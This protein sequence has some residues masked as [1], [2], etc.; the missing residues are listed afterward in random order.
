MD[1]L[2]RA[3][4]VRVRLARAVVA[5]V[6]LAGARQ[7]RHLL[8]DVRAGRGLRPRAAAGSVEGELRRAAER[9]AHQ[10]HGPEDVRP[11]HRRPRGDGRS[12][13]VA[14]HRVHRA[15]AERRD[16]RQRVAHRVQAAE[17]TE[18]AVVVR[19]PAGGAAVAALV[20]GDDVVARVGQRRQDVPPAIG[21]LREAVQEEQRRPPPALEAGFEHVHRQA[22]DVVDEPRADAVR[23]PAR[24][25]GT[26]F[27]RLRGRCGGA[28]R[29]GGPRRRRCFAAP[30]A[31]HRGGPEDRADARQRL[32]PRD[33]TPC[34]RLSRRASPAG[35]GSCLSSVCDVRRSSPPAGRPCAAC[36][37][38][39]KPLTPPASFQ[40]VRRPALRR[41][42]ALAEMARRDTVVPC[43]PP[44]GFGAANRVR[45]RASTATALP[46]RA[47]RSTPR[48]A[49]ADRPP[50]AGRAGRGPTCPGTAPAR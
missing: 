18:T 46:V 34:N 23:Q 10:R 37:E 21:Q 16:Q 9:G 15:V 26:D 28:L 5:L 22:V 2:R 43:R 47:G 19:A 20:G 41:A 38:G 29:A 50:A 39:V 25:V 31:H 6:V 8:V 1:P 45:P 13:V 35:H 32:A 49:P 24:V 14:D 27:L 7:A 30:L 36:V 3:P 12:E 48:P 4:H 33:P 44:A 42:V 11:R 40:S 17:R